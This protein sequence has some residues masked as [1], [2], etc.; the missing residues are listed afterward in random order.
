M[1][2]RVHPMSRARLSSR[3]PLQSRMHSLALAAGLAVLIGVGCAGC[4]GGVR[5]GEGALSTASAPQVMPVS[6]QESEERRRA[7]IRLELGAS[8]YQQGSYAVA[9]EELRQALQID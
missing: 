2:E 9:L 7:R 6:T 8:Y 4:A 1:N 3:L 5:S